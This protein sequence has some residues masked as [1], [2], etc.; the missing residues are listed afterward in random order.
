MFDGDEETQEKG[1]DEDVGEG[2]V[3]GGVEEWAFF[4]CFCFFLVVLG[5]GGGRGKK[6]EGFEYGGPDGTE[7][8]ESGGDGC[9]VLGL[10]GGGGGRGRGGR[11]IC[12]EKRPNDGLNA[13]HVCVDEQGRS[14]TNQGAVES[15][16]WWKE[17]MASF[18]R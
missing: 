4:F 5:G 16:A 18:L 12:A 6:E 13:R 14:G 11:V 1:G 8:I 3:A 10:V 17:T 2:G 9:V 15:R 7:G